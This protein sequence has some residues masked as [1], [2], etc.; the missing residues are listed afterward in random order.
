MFGVSSVSVYLSYIHCDADLTA[1]GEALAKAL[2]AEFGADACE[3]LGVTEDEATRVLAAMVLSAENPI[4]LNDAPGTRAKASN[5]RKMRGQ[6]PFTSQQ[7]AAL[8][9]DSFL[10]LHPRN[11]LSMRVWCCFS[12]TFGTRIL[13]TALLTISQIWDTQREALY[14]EIKMLT[15]PWGVERMNGLVQPGRE[16][17]SVTELQVEQAALRIVE[18]GHNKSLPDVRKKLGKARMDLDSFQRAQVKMGGSVDF[19]SS[20]GLRAP[21]TRLEEVALVLGVRNFLRMEGVDES[22]EHVSGRGPVVAGKATDVSWKGVHA[23]LHGAGLLHP[24]RLSN[25]IK[26]HFNDFLRPLVGQRTKSAKWELSMV[27][28]AAYLRRYRV[29]AGLTVEEVE[30]AGLPSRRKGQAQSLGPGE[31]AAGG[32]GGNGELSACESEEREEGGDSSSEV[33]E[34]AFVRKVKKKG[35]RR[36]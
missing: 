18:A 32:G 26:E 22:D 13:E 9:T 36:S 3:E 28:M 27:K 12:M 14:A 30:G 34:E 1:K 19:V 29:A 21:Y 24:K 35:G 5:G 23:D 31:S 10:H 4:S 7:L 8:L 17:P 16:R 33:D 6:L 15:K 2:H 25:D 20:N 11:L